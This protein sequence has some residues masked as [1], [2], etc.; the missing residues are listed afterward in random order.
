MH[1]QQQCSCCFHASSLQRAQHHI[2][3]IITLH[4]WSNQAC[5]SMM[6]IGNRGMFSNAPE[7]CRNLGAAERHRP[8][9]SR[10]L[11]RL[12][13]KLCRACVV[14]NATLPPT[15]PTGSCASMQVSTKLLRNVLLLALAARAH[16]AK[17]SCFGITPCPLPASGAATAE[18]T[19]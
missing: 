1:R 18:P 17:R 19:G 2:H 14:S 15:P 3:V 8:V 6:I 11:W 7:S 13:R 16:A 10:Q 4:L 5:E 9:A 12:C